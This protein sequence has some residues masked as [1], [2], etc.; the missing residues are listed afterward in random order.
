MGLDDPERVTSLVVLPTLPTR[1]SRY[2][3][4][5]ELRLFDRYRMLG[6]AGSLALAVGGVAAGALP[7]DDPF[8]GIPPV[9]WLRGSE[10]LAHAV[11]YAGLAL[12]VVAWLF[13][14]R[15][16]GTPGGPGPRSLLTTLAVWSAPLC[17]APPMFSRDVYSYNAQGWM[18]HVGAS[19]YF[20]GPGAIPENPFLGDVPD[21]WTHTPAPYGPLFLQMA[22]WVVDLGGDRTVP[23]VLGMRVLALA[24]VLML[25]RYVPR[26]A[27]HCGVPADRA[28][29]LG[30]LN[31]LVIFHFVSGAH[32]DSLLVGLMVAGLVLVLDRRPVLGIVLVTL[33]LLIKAPA[34]LALVFLVPFL[35]Q[36]MPGRFRLVS[37][38]AV[39]GAVSGSV[40]VVVSWAT[41]LGYGWIGA[42][43][44]PGTVRNWLSISTLL[45]EAV[46]LVA[47]VAGYGETA[48]DAM[49]E[50][51]SVFRGIG[52]VLAI[53]V[54]GLLLLRMER[55]GLI[56]SLGIGF[57]AVVTLSP[58]VQP[59]YL[60]WGFV[61]LAA[62]VP[63]VKIRSAVVVLSAFLAVVVMPKGG[64]VD[65]SAIIQAV[66][67]AAVV[68]G[69]VAV[70]ELLPGRGAGRDCDAP[71]LGPVAPRGNPAAHT[72]TADAPGITVTGTPAE[73]A[74]STRR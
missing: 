3:A 4:A 11:G 36:R 39:V 18:V 68:A 51:I 74:A 33:G 13:L 14:G 21:L 60:L 69:S 26:L 54:V 55:Y 35:A 59:W 50:A 73:T 5:G 2:R 42:L 37:A 1:L 32:N 48:D 34:A 45:G 67:C 28:L 57:V 66:L 70:F 20:W 63:A 40:I 62:G 8:T 10:P 61:L 72:S 44:T 52:G 71:V 23:T 15:R 47:Y 29:W 49:T 9:N 30:V 43:N 16:V 7:L 64:T 65:I 25:V 38:A 58:V 31:P 19:P 24:G 12:L 6:F 46:G 22:R 56:G 53:A 27:A 41:G 17:L